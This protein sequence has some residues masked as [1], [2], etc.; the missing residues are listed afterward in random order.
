MSE[1][2]LI[3][4][5]INKEPKFTKK[6]NINEKLS[7]IRNLLKEKLPKDSLFT[8]S[9]GCEIDIEDENDYQL[10]EIIDEGKV[11]IKSNSSNISLNT[12]APSNKNIPIEGS[13]LISKKGK[14]D[15]YL[16][17]K[18]ELNEEEKEKAIT[19]MVLGQTGCGKTTLINS[20]LNYILGI[21][22]EDNFRYE[23]V[24]M[25]NGK[26]SYESQTSNV[27][28][29]NIKGI[30]ELPPFQIIDT[31]GFGNTKGINHQIDK[32]FKEKIS[33]L[34]AICLVA[35]SSN[36]RLTVN[37]KYI[38]TSILN[39]FSEDM[40]EN[41]MALLTFCDGGTPQIVSTLERPDFMFS[42]L[43]PYLNKPWYY[44][45]NNSA[46]FDDNLEEEFP[47]FFFK[48]SMKS[49][50]EF[51]KRL[52]K[53]PK[54][55]LI[56]TK[57]VLEERNKLDKFSEILTNKLAEGIDK[58]NYIKD[59]LNTISTLKRDLNNSK[60]IPKSYLDTKIKLFKESKNELIN[61]DNECINTQEQII[62]S[63]NR[64]KQIALNKNELEL[65]EEYIELL[66]ENE[67]CEQKLDYEARIEQLE[68]LKQNKILIKE[69]YK[70][71]NNKMKHI[72]HFIENSL[73]E[74]NI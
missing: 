47:K 32:L 52:I 2:I 55:S 22:I 54:K 45:F 21:Q 48:I 33:N 67:K 27:E 11:Y 12:K 66:I 42:S 23:F 70:R 17:P 68:H 25:E 43:I 34:N 72:K 73:N 51:K 16:Y 61:I 6:Y 35:Q 53:M 9:D 44:K 63:I 1:K 26:F 41:F 10:S 62:K 24:H 40:K 14:L 3:R 15:I 71:E 4:F 46:I 60:N 28:V 13:K 39:L 5:L 59:L 36:A 74:E 49:F 30:N 18:I 8:L 19:F 56:Q 64:L 29:Y 57:Q 38:F 50:E 58:V 69:I 20:F 31:P 37:Q 65:S 7:E